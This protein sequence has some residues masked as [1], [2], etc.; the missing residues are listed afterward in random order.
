MNNTAQQRKVSTFYLV[1]P[2]PMPHDVVI[3]KQRNAGVDI[4][5]FGAGCKEHIQARMSSTRFM[6][7]IVSVDSTGYFY[8]I[9]V[10]VKPNCAYK[11]YLPRVAN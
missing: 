9:N 6:K 5:L 4:I 1:L 8:P 11:I 3:S 7:K 10:S 2:E